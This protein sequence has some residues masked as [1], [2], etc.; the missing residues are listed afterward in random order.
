M[1]RKPLIASDGYV[2]TDGTIYGYKIFLAVGRSED[3]FYEITQEEYE[4]ILEKEAQ[5]NG[6][7]EV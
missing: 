7:T 1:A 2:L 5:A 6:S 3:E 4:K